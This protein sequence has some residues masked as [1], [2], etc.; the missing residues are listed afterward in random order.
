ML[1]KNIFVYPKYP[2]SLKKLFNLAYN[3]W[4]L[5]DAEVCQVFNEI[6]RELF[7]N[8]NR[9][10]VEFL[11]SLPAERI[12]K[13]SKNKRFLENLEKVWEK[14]EKYSERRTEYQE[15]FKDNNIAYFSM[16]YGLH[17]AVPIYAGGLGVLAGDHLK[18]ASDLGV[19]LTGVGLLYRYGYFHQ[20]ITIDGIQEEDNKENNVYYIP[21]REMRTGS[22]EPLY[23]TVN[24]LKN[25]VKVKVWAVQIGRV[26][27][28]L[29]DTNLEE[30]K[31][32]FRGIT[33]FLYDAR[34]DTRFMQEMV[35][36]FGGM[37]ALKALGIS[38]D[39]F[40]LNE[41]HSAFLIIQRLNNLM[42][43]NHYT[44][45]EAY[46]LIKSTTVFTTHTPV[47]AGNENYPVEMVAKYLEEKVQDIKIPIDQL[48]RYG[49]LH[50]EKT[51][52]LPA[53]AIRFVRYVNGVSKIHSEVSRK[54]WKAL[55]PQRMICE[56]PIQHITNGVHHSW[57]SN[58]M[59]K[60]LETHLCNDYLSLE[61]TQQLD[62]KIREIPDEELWDAHLKRKRDT[63]AYLRMI[64][65]ENFTEQG[66]S[67]VKIRKAQEILNTNSLTIGFARRFTAYKRPTL[68]IR[69]KERLKSIL[70]DPDRPVQLIFAGKAHPADTAGKS[71]IKEIL[72]FAKEFEVEDRVV[73]IENY[74]LVIAEYLV[75]GVDVW[76]NTPIKPFEASG[77]SGMKAGMNGVL[78]LSILDGWWPECYNEKNGWAVKSGNQS[79]H[80][81]LRDR[82]EAS[83]IYDLLEEVVTACY[84]ERDE[85]DIPRKWVGMMKES[86]AS[87]LKNFNINRMLMEYCD[88][89]YKPAL[90]DSKRFIENEGQQLKQLLSTAQ[91]VKVFWDKIYIKDVFMDIDKRD[92]LFTDDVIHTGCYVFLDD[93][94]SEDID[95]E[96]FYCLEMAETFETVKLD[97]IEKYKDKVAKFEGNVVLRSSGL[98][99]VGVRVV[100]SD[101]DIR[102]LYPELIKWKEY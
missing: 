89:C 70:T 61:E 35:L 93:S 75:Q 57:L 41:G 25:Q 9:N 73:F 5:W 54:M 28:L 14:F 53:F 72:D 50:D 31:P 11:L 30:N 69:D 90:V 46:A 18:G 49:A 101:R 29:L 81:D 63:I 3:L 84:Y 34:R 76:L 40:H 79:D 102:M 33:D 17:E 68:I 36:G 32:E 98:Q 39:V 88:T 47:E 44:F 7:R 52:W 15:R 38:P 24:I 77:T 8:V 20:K 83:L 1:L 42:L 19:P 100:P 92:V 95:V 58:Q 10:P 64:V 71:M 67:Q 87:V 45:S 60:L 80:S 2:D 4:S 94:G 59:K 26:K 86:I 62:Q 22:G 23:I 66:Y 27:I 74:D 56:I 16:E 91:R 97:F 21:V 85:R 78:N 51:F 65:E 82:T 12:D 96:L 48:L 99:R 37:K 6:D 43:E 55:F 13:L